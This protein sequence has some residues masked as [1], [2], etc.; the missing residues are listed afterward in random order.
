MGKPGLPLVKAL[1]LAATDHDDGSGS[2]SGRGFC[3][4][5]VRVGESYPA[6]AANAASAV[7]KRAP[8]RRAK[9]RKSP[10]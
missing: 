8:S 6:A 9:V 1:Q 2:G 7:N 5:G 10:S 4:I 3:G